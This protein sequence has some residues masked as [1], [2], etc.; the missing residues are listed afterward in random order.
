MLIRDTSKQLTSVIG[1]VDKCCGRSAGV[2]TG[3]GFL[4]LRAHASSLTA[5]LLSGCY[6]VVPAR[7]TALAGAR[8]LV[9]LR[10]T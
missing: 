6:P 9:K 7:Q 3:L 8:Y 5:A 4:D 2:Q 10:A 1:D